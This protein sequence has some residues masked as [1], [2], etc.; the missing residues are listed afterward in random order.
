MQF[1]YNN[2]FKTK[3]HFKQSYYFSSIKKEPVL[4]F[5]TKGLKNSGGRN[6]LGVIT[7]FHKGGGH[8][9]LYR[10][11]NFSLMNDFV[12]V[13]MSIE[14]DPNRTANIAAI[15]CE[16]KKQYFYVI[17]PKGLKKGNFIRSGSQALTRLGH[18]LTLDKIPLGSF[19]HNVSY[20]KLKG[21]ISRA[22]GA[23]SQLLEKTATH[24]IIKVNSGRHLSISLKNKASLGKVSNENFWL[25]KKRKAGQSRWL[26]IRPTVRGVAMNP[27]DHPHGGGE[28]KSSKKMAPRTP[29]GKL[30]KQGSTRKSKKNKFML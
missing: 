1:K 27:I 5:K 9:Q 29:W 20:T 28:G 13:V 16:E 25:K 2:F 8:K 12:G 26:N 17:A 23:F 22:A 21:T 19:I 14:Y 18:N 3:H 24:G 7:S 4:K 6:N 11:I 30:V 15:Y 10:L